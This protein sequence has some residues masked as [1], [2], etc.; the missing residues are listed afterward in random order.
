M[1]AVARVIALIGLVPM[2]GCTPA[3]LGAWV[4]WY[5][6]DPVAA[7]EFANRPEVQTALADAN[8]TPP[9]RRESLWDD[10]AWC[11]S[12]GQWDH[13]PVS[14][15]HGTF[16]G[17]LMIGHQWWSHYGGETSAPYLASK[18]EQI[19]VAENIAADNGLDAAWQCYP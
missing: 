4:G 14:N 18:A 1:R 2:T 19:A 11:E 12:G 7:T 9:I 13:E 3:E 6:R 5:E 8:D 17:G 15:R 10:I 16:S